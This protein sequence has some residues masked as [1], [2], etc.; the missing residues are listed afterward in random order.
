VA[1]GPSAVD[2]GKKQPETKVKDIVADR[3]AESAERLGTKLKGG[4]GRKRKR[5]TS[6]PLLLRRR[7]MLRLRRGGRV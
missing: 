5:E 4:E 7:K 6:N 2:I 1:F 3:L